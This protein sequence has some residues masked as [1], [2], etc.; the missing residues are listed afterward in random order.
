[1]NCSGHCT[2]VA[3]RSGPV[4]AGFA[5]AIAGVLAFASAGARGKRPPVG[6]EGLR[7]RAFR[8]PDIADGAGNARGVRS[9]LGADVRRDGG[10]GG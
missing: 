8:F 5:R 1:M 6:P 4:R 3:T 10:R 2:D 7:R 9:E